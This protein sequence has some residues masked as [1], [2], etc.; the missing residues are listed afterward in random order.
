LNSPIQKAE[1]DIWFAEPCIFN[2][3]RRS[4][5]A[6]VD[7]KTIAAVI[8]LHIIDCIKIKDW[9]IARTASILN[10]SVTGN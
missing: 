1:Y 10:N 5:H 8:L 3:V 7:D 9:P 2:Q 4:W 6:A